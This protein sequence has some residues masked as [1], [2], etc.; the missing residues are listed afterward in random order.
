[1]SVLVCRTN[2]CEHAYGGISREGPFGASGALPKDRYP[3]LHGA[4]AFLLCS[5]PPSNGCMQHQ[6]RYGDIVDTS[7]FLSL[8]PY[9]L[10]VID[11]EGS[12][13]R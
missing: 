12:F 10:L 4:V 9:V 6:W 5:C 2:C 1:M 13:L 3:D 8:L 11:L 7:M